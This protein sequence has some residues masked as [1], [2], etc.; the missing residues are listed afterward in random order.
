LRVIW[1]HKVLVGMHH[2]FTASSWYKPITTF[3]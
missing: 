2:M 1:N 3:N